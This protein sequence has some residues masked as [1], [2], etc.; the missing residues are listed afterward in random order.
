MPVPVRCDVCGKVFSSSHV[1]SHKRLAH[2]KDRAAGATAPEQGMKTILEIY[3]A[4]S[5]ENKKRV[6]A[7]LASMEQQPS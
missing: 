5:A 1:N 4:L 6:L 3:S 7:K 2:P